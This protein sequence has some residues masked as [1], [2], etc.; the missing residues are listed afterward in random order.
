MLTPDYQSVKYAAD[1]ANAINRR[2]YIPEKGIQT[3]MAKAKTDEYIELNVHP[4][5]RT[6]SRGI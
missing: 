6:I 5:T 2:F 1:V 4:A 3:G